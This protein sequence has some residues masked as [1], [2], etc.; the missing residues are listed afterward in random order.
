M[1]SKGFTNCYNLPLNKLR[2]VEIRIIRS[3]LFHSVIADWMKVFVKKLSLALT[4]GILFA[5]LEA[6]SLVV[7]GIISLKY[8]D[9]KLFN[10]V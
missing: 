6:C 4:K 8:L 5:F 3:S 10:I 2:L 1:F 7:L 9:N